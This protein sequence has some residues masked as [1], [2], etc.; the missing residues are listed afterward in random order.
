MKTTRGVSMVNAKPL[1]P[2]E[3]ISPKLQA[4]DKVRQAWVSQGKNPTV[5]Q[6]LLD[7]EYE[8]ANTD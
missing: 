6:A 2:Q 3:P 5:T 8:A 1:P 4:W 7:A